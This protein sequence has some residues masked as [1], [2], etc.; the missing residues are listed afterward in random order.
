ML[1]SC[2]DSTSTCQFYRHTIMWVLQTK[3]HAIDASACYHRAVRSSQLSTD[4]SW[5]VWVRH[6]HRHAII[7]LWVRVTVRQTIHRHATMIPVI[8]WLRQTHRHPVSWKDTFTCY[9]HLVSSSHCS[10]DDTSACYYDSCHRVSSSHCSTDDTS[11]C[12]YD[13]SH[14]VSPTDTSACYHHLVSWHNGVVS[15]CDSCEL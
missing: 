14:R 7:V 2:C 6:K 12:Y 5:L 13:S 3:L 4:T 11:A 10:T 15:S 1:S 8:V 9:H